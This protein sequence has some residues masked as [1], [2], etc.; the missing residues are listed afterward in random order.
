MSLPKGQIEQIKK[1]LIDQ[2][3]SNFPEEKKN[4]SIEQINNMNEKEL[5][6]FLVQN[7]LIKEDDAQNCIFCS[8][9]TN[10]IP[11]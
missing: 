8:I 4:S 10:Q 6:D 2:I 3:R 1:Q 9:L 5:E 7:N 11:S